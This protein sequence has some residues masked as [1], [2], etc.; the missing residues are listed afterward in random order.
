MLSIRADFPHDRHWHRATIEFSDGSR[1]TI[2]IEKKAEGQTFNFSKRTVDWLRI[3]DLIQD[4]PLGWCGFTEVEVW[5]R[6]AASDTS[7][8]EHPSAGHVSS[9]P[10]RSSQR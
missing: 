5:G 6:D 4:E 1:E 10:A 2:S 7:R 3:T 8:V 9:V